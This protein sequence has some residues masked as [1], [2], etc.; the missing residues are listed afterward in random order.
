[1]N[2]H[3]ATAQQKAPQVAGRGVMLS[4]RAAPLY[5]SFC[6]ECMPS[7]MQL[8]KFIHQSVKYVSTEGP[9]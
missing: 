3:G 6:N 8:I 4:S 9:Y 2:G 7:K 5:R 1:M